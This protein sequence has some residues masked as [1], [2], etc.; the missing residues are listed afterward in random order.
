[1]Q[2]VPLGR[3][4]TGASAGNSSGLD[5]TCDHGVLT[6]D[7]TPARSPLELLGALAK[8]DAEISGQSRLA[9]IYTVEG[10]LQI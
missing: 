6:D 1:M 4:G 9:E 8:T 5:L 2:A 7:P 3:S 10:L